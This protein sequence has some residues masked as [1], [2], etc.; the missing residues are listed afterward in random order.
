V[1]NCGQNCSTERDN[2]HTLW[3]PLLAL[4]ST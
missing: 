2:S 1:I 3:V 4:I